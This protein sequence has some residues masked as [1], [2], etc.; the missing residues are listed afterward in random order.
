MSEISWAMFESSSHGLEMNLNDL[1]KKLGRDDLD[2][3]VDTLVAARLVRKAP[4]TQAVSFVH[5]RFN[6]YF[7]VSKWLNGERRPPY[8]AIPTASR[9]RDAL[10]LHAEVTGHAE[11]MALAEYCWHEMKDFPPDLMKESG[12]QLRVLRAVH[13]LR[14]LTEAFRARGEAL[15]A[16]RDQLDKKVLALL[17]NTNDLLYQKIAV[18]TSGSIGSETTES[19]LIFALRK[20]NAWLQEAAFGVC[21]FIQWL[22]DRVSKRLKEVLSQQH[23]WEI[24]FPD[25]DLKFTLG[26]S[27]V[28]RST[29]LFYRCLRF[30]AVKE[31][32]LI[33]DFKIIL[34]YI[35][36]KHNNEVLSIYLIISLLSYFT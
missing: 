14:F 25:K 31:I 1:R 11:A 7:L 20:G 2:D 12:G 4:R 19:V 24:I 34:S 22:P 26:A 18:E 27:D 15:A 35:A 6:E 16:F 8:D 30:D 36:I 5:R 13:C 21:R 32:F 33:I 17:N 10:V 29:D 9:Y 28:S 3:L 23:R